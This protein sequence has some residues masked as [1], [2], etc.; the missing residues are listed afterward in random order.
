ML[1]TEIK[2]NELTRRAIFMAILFKNQKCSEADLGLNDDENFSR[3]RQCS[4]NIR[5]IHSRI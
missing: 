2:K 1:R 4:L 5:L 3:C